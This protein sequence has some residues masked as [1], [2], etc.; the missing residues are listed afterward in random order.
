MQAEHTSEWDKRELLEKDKQGLEK[1]NRRLKVRVKEMEELLHRRNRFSESSE[2]PDFKTSGVEL[3]EKHKVWDLFGS[4]CPHFLCIFAL[5][6]GGHHLN[7]HNFK[8]EYI[9]L[10]V[11]SYLIV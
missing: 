2:G 3:Q 1:E 5:R 4:K 7:F 10:C 9:F 8:S 11:I 6:P